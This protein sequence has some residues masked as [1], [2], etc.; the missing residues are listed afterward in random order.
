MS[1]FVEQISHYITMLIANGE[2]SIT[3]LTINNTVNDICSIVMVILM[4]IY[5]VMLA[6]GIAGSVCQFKDFIDNRKE[7]ADEKE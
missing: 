1:E 2:D 4:M 3:W 5:V 6:V 7:I